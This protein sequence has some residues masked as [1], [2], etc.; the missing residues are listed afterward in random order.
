MTKPDEPMELVRG[1]GNV[2]TDF[3]AANADARQLKAKLA[4]EIIK[5]L[6]E[7]RLTV[8]K[9]QALTGIDAGDFSRIRGAELGRFTVDRL[10]N[11]VNRL[12][13]RV[14]VTL[15]VRRGSADGR[16]GLQPGL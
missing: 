8:R 11:I 9:A 5:T 13:Q 3:G 12:G 14:E 4:A 2:Y 10:L 16:S 7:Q 6:D 15:T 1:S